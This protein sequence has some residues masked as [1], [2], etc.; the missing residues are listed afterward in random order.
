MESEGERE[1]EGC[2]GHPGQRCS[3]GY[4]RSAASRKADRKLEVRKLQPLANLEL[5]GAYATV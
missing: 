3:P 4:T 5:L 2:Q 1:S